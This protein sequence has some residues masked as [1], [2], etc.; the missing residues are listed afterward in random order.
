MIEQYKLF[1]D[2]HQFHLATSTCTR[3][4]RVD[5]F[6][7]RL[8]SFWAA[9]APPPPPETETAD[10]EFPESD[11]ESGQDEVSPLLPPPPP[12]PST[13]FFNARPVDEFFN[14][15]SRGK[16]PFRKFS[17]EL[18]A[19]AAA[20]VAATT[21]ATALGAI[22]TRYDLALGPRPSK[23]VGP[24]FSCFLR[25][26]SRLVCCPKHRSQRGHL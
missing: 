8:V 5:R 13:L 1:F 14:G 22:L 3:L 18:V 21:A 19:A 23:I 25:C 26:R 2:F 7:N 9:V 20:W 16:L 4:F 11:D 24:S 15:E 10:P 17:G 6:F 12:P